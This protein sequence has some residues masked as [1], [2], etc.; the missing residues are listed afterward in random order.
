[1]SAF[2]KRERK[3]NQTYRL[4]LTDEEEY[5]YYVGRMGGEKRLEENF[6][7][8]YREIQK[9]RNEPHGRGHEGKVRRMNES[10]GY[11]GEERGDVQFTCFEFDFVKSEDA[12]PSK[13]AK[14]GSSDYYIQANVNGSY[15][16]AM[17]DVGDAARNADTF[18][19]YL[20]GEVVDTSP[21]GQ[22]FIEIEVFRKKVNATFTE[23]RSELQYPGRLFLNREI[24]LHMTA[25][26]VKDVPSNNQNAQ[27]VASATEQSVL[28]A[29]EYE[30]KQ[31]INET[32]KP[33]AKIEVDDPVSQ[34][35][36]SETINVLYGREASFIAPKNPDYEY[37]ENNK[38]SGAL[39]TI[40][41]IKGRVTLKK[42]TADD[43]AEFAG[44]TKP[45]GAKD[46]TR[47]SLSYADADWIL[48]QRRTDKY[49]LYNKMLENFS[50]TQDANGGHEDVLH[51]DL[52][53]PD[54]KDD[55]PDERRYDWG[56]DVTSE[57]TELDQRSRT[58]RLIGQFTYDVRR[59][60]EGVDVG[61]NPYTISILSI[62]KEEL[63]GLETKREYYKSV[64]DSNQLYV[65]LIYIWWGCHAR[66]ANILLEDGTTK[67]AD[68]V[69]PG[70]KLPCHGGKTLVVSNVYTGFEKDLYHVKVESGGEV[71]VSSGHPLLGEDGT[72]IVVEGLRPGD[73]V[74]LADQ[75]LATVTAVEKQPYHDDVYNF[76]FE[77]EDEGN[78]L[79]ANG[80]F[81]GD[82]YAQNKLPQEEATLT[83]ESEALI[84]E[85]SRLVKK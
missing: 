51:F 12:N 13:T 83:P 11:G 19:V 81:S 74:V 18:T 21:G 84:E 4:D 24:K 47:S 8:L 59:T 67:R 79:V 9:A 28:N 16:D 53:N 34:T 35:A 68:E 54:F 55:P 70:D 25:T 39:H 36:D 31:M 60:I 77:G 58:C 41:P 82:F 71:R 73:G 2:K 29:Y 80:F 76:V 72:G 44:L 17:K 22:Q 20:K 1:M 43:C 37:K 57:V 69:A 30:Y 64:E 15:L 52:Y 3:P 46:I 49:D 48:Y 65:P 14:E 7:L 40:L 6:P 56:D 26:V 33:Y 50:V 23:V 61:A 85:M 10:K 66:D 75:S 27:N 42:G 38:G 45:A 5:A 62:S 32:G 78:Y 63:D